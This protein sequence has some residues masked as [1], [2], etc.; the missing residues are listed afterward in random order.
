[1]EKT[2]KFQIIYASHT[3]LCKQTYARYLKKLGLPQSPHYLIGVKRVHVNSPNVEGTVFQ[4]FW[5]YKQRSCIQFM[6]NEQV[7]LIPF[8]WEGVN[9]TLGIRCVP[10]RDIPGTLSMKYW[11]LASRKLSTFRA[12]GWALRSH[13][14][15]S[16]QGRWHQ[17]S[18][19]RFNPSH[20]TV[21]LTDSWLGYKISADK[22]ILDF[23]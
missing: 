8:I 2:R 15:L 10:L 14:G 12:W 16:N 22:I 19:P 18:N 9:F 1:M 11:N 21:R 13:D 6:T 4:R 17:I 7:K 20:L 23:S 5:N 3:N